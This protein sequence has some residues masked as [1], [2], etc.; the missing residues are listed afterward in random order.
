MQN[1]KGSGTIK[2]QTQSWTE[3]FEQ[4]IQYYSSINI[5]QVISYTT[6]VSLFWVF[7][8]YIWKMYFGRETGYLLSWFFEEL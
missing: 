8:G 5:I 4:I 7:Y 3:H 6:V 1:L 2:N